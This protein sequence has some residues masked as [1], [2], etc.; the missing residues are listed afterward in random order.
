MH[1]SLLLRNLSKLP[2]IWRRRAVAA[3]DGSLDDLLALAP[4]VISDR[5][6]H[7]VLLLP[8]LYTTLDATPIPEIVVQFDSSSGPLA[9]S[10]TCISRCMFALHLLQCLCAERIA[11]S[12]AVADLWPRCWEWIRF[13]DTHREYLHWVPPAVAASTPILPVSTIMAMSLHHLV[14]RLI[15]TTPGVRVVLVSGWDVLLAADN[16]LGNKDTFFRLCDFLSSGL[17]LTGSGNLDEA[18]EGAGGSRTHLASLVV[19]HITR[20]LLEDSIVNKAAPVSAIF[21]IVAQWLRDD[22]EFQKALLDQGIVTAVTSVACLLSRP[23]LNSDANVLKAFLT[24]LVQCSIHSPSHI[25]I[26]E[27]LKAGLLTVIVACGHRID[28]QT[29]NLVDAIIDVLKTSLVYRSVLLQIGISLAQVDMHAATGAWRQSALFDKWRTFLELAEERVQILEDYENMIPQRACD[30]SEFSRQ[31]VKNMTGNRPEVIATVV[32]YFGLSIRVSVALVSRWPCFNDVH[33]AAH[34]HLNARNKWF[35]RALLHEC[36]RAVRPLL[37][38][39]VLNF[40]RAGTTPGESPYV[41]FDLTDPD[42]PCRV[43]LGPVSELQEMSSFVSQARNSGGRIQLHV[44]T[45][46]D[47]CNPRSWIFPLRSSSGD[48]MRGLQLM[49]EEMPLPGDE[50]EEERIEALLALDVV[51][52][53]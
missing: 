49:A 45:V 22:I 28:V 7:Q 13:I 43:S 32:K 30:N 20:V 48:V 12:A 19:K 6:V 53:H 4:L 38:R 41:L 9:E 26:Q 3:A 5:Q 14:E 52:I 42:S 2:S 50:R 46:Q 25:W 15:R 34:F 47:G 8:V 27:S 33:P 11:V 39:K 44:V 29:A 17:D 51:E 35:L 37:F 16:L 23:P 31:P 40:M 36:Y 21:P 24:L 18:L 10:K 1:P